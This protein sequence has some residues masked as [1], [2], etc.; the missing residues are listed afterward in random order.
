MSFT[1]FF[2]FIFL[3]ANIEL[4]QLEQNECM[5]AHSQSRQDLRRPWSLSEAILRHWSQVPCK[6]YVALHCFTTLQPAR[7][8]HLVH[9]VYELSWL[10]WGRLLGLYYGPS[11]KI[12]QN[13]LSIL[14][15]VILLLSFKKMYE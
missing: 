2:F 1:D 6:T 11:K 10:W 14:F 5:A 8:K 13:I 4:E 12:M 9:S 3:F 15:I 7:L